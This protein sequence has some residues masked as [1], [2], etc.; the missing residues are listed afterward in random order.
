MLQPYVMKCRYIDTFPFFFVCMLAGT[1]AHV[2]KHCQK[3]ERSA[4]RGL[5]S[6]CCGAD[7][8]SSV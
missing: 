3:S 1:L 6:L 2:Q 8:K 5:T 4:R 7:V